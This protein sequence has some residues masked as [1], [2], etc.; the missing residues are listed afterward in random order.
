M[1]TNNLNER[2]LLTRLSGYNVS[3]ESEQ[4]VLIFSTDFLLWFNALRKNLS[5]GNLSSKKNNSGFFWVFLAS[6]SLVS[7]IRT[8]QGF[9]SLTILYLSFI[10][11]LRE[12]K[13]I[14][15]NASDA[16]DP[17]YPNQRKSFKDS[18]KVDANIKQPWQGQG[19]FEMS[20]TIKCRARASR[21]KLQANGDILWDGVVMNLTKGN[22]IDTRVDE[23][24]LRA[25][26]EQVGVGIAAVGLD[27]QFLQ[28]NGKL[29][30]ITGYVR[31]E[32]LTKTIFQLTHPDD[33]AIERRFLRLLKSQKQA[34]NLEKRYI[35]RTGAVIWV[36]VNA[37]VVRDPQ[38]N[39]KF[40]IGMIEDITDQ[41]LAQDTLRGSEAQLRSLIEKASELILSS[42][43]TI[44][45]AGL[46]LKQQLGYEQTDL[47][48]LD[49]FQ[50]IHRE[51]HLKVNKLLTQIVQEPCG[52]ILLEFRVR[53]QNGNWQPIKVIGQS[54]L[55]QIGGMNI[56]VN[57]LQATVQKSE[58][59][60]GLERVCLL[61]LAAQVGVAI[62][63]CHTLAAKLR[64]CAE[65]IS[66]QLKGAS[67]A[68]W[69]LNPATQQLEPQVISGEIFP[70]DDLIKIV[71]QTRQPQ[72]L[73]QQTPQ[74]YLAAYPL[75]AEDKLL[76]V[77]A[78]LS[79]YF[80]S[81]EASDTLNWVANA[82]AQGINSAQASELL[83]YQ[84]TRL[85]ELTSQIRNSLELN[86]ILNTGVQSIRS[87]LQTERC[88]FSWS[89]QETI[90]EWKVVYEAKNPLLSSHLGCYK[91][92]LMGQVAQ[93]QNQQ[94]WQIDAVADLEDA[95]SR[96]FFQGL[97]YTSVLLMP[98]QTDAGEMGVI[99]CGNSTPRVWESR[100]LELLS[101]VVG[102]LTKAI[103]QAV[104]YQQAKVTAQIAQAEV[105]QLELA[106]KELQS[107]QAR[108]VQSE[109]MSSLGQLVAGI[110]HEI[111][112]P[113]N[114]IH[115]NLAYAS[116]YF[117]DILSLLDL[118]KEHYPTPA[119]AIVEQ[120]EM[121]NLN[122]IA[123]DLPKLLNSMQRGTDRIRSIV[124]S[125]R[126]FSRLDEA[127]MKQADL[128]EGIES[129]LSIL[130][131][132]LN[133]K[134]QHPEIQVFR[135]YANLPNVQCYP[136]Q[137]NQVFMNIISNAIEALH[138]PQGANQADLGISDQA[139]PAITISTSFLDSQD[140]DP[141]LGGLLSQKPT[142]KTS[143][144]L[145]RIAD[146]G[147]GMSELV[148]TKLFDPFFTTKPVGQ[149]IGLGLSISYQIVVEHHRGVLTCTSTPGKGTEFWIEI[150]IQKVD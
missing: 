27:G 99:I 23:E 87:L 2:Q 42:A 94:I 33:Q 65:A 103:N 111:N 22:S 7:V 31:E 8:R 15:K 107:T 40:Y 17:I 131:H 49:L 71:A 90:A 124:L 115:G 89:N 150:P 129:T 62:S 20:G 29:C 122:F 146:N 142:Q 57:S 86:V 127:D 16:L 130:Q 45:Y 58:P 46:A 145:I 69:T 117:Y 119:A 37:S 63:N 61:D 43:G 18:V 100:E 81:E 101:A 82:I 113:V 10:T 128:H 6:V 59:A 9:R 54:V 24:Q 44:R 1:V 96:Q 67:I 112:N 55:D 4:L 60:V 126:H 75:V 56:V 106:L 19:R 97:G 35:C 104:V 72:F 132:R 137:L 125:L 136:G 149:G 25:I 80:L 77:L 70:L 3:L 34:S 36:N 51:D 14:Q 102:Q 21:P 74:N 84:E 135:D 64:G 13:Q 148:R 92:D 116:A 85:F 118:Y 133:S 91:T 30:E 143:S 108:L 134:G 98:L 78:V 68:I 76:G 93:M 110:A 83:N 138:Q 48:G 105:Q 141:S 39:P 79:N 12:S 123:K 109:K 139:S 41:K 144:V 50:L 47:V 120:S 73:Q 11:T 95:K 114:F 32:L 26:F 28:V 147:P 5:Q 38:G 66:R 88:C 121:I 140:S 52:E 53:H